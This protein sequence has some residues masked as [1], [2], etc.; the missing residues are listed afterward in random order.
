MFFKVLPTC[1][2]RKEILTRATTQV[3]LEDIMLTEICKPQNDKYRM[4][5]P[6]QVTGEVE[7]TETEGR[8]VVAG[9]WGERGRENCSMG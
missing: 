2:I 7:I 5:P 8:M 6:P 9:G 1:L 4:I 3:N